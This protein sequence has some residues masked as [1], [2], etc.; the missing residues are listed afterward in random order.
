M[1]EASVEKVDT[2]GDGCKVTIK[3]KKG[4]QQVD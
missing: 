3:T 2:K 1:T 4:E